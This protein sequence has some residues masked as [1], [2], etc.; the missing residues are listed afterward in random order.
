MVVAASDVN[1]SVPVIVSENDSRSVIVVS[2]VACSV[3]EDAMVVVTSIVTKVS[4][5]GVEESVVVSAVEA[6]VENDVVAEE[7]SV[8]SG[9][10]VAEVSTPTTAD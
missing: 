3:I 1:S 5:V 4:D 8:A 9:S 7:V 2:N 6:S 10:L